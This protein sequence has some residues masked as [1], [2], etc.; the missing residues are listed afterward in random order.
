[1]TDSKN[2]EV[3]LVPPHRKGT[4][5]IVTI[6]VDTFVSVGD[7]PLTLVVRF[8]EKLSQVLR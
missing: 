3:A 2:D 4:R 7:I 6:D 1:M 5:A 8:T